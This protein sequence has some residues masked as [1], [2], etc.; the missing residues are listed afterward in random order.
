MRQPKIAIRIRVNAFTEKKSLDVQRNSNIL[1]L[2]T[3]F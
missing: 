3:N 2:F 1:V